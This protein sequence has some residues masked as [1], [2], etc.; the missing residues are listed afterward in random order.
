MILNIQK[1]ITLSENGIHLNWQILK[2]GRLIPKRQKE[3]APRLSLG[4][5]FLRKT[6]HLSGII[7]PV[8]YSF[9]PRNDVLAWLVAGLGVAFIVEFLRLTNSGFARLFNRYWGFLL[10]NGEQRH[11]CGATYWLVGAFLV[12]FFFPQ[13]IALFS[14]YILIVSDSLAA[15]VGRSL[16]RIRLIR[17]KTLE[18]SAAFFVSA[19]LIGS[20]IP[21]HTAGQVLVGALAGTLFELGIIPL[22]DNLTIPVGTA[23]VLAALPVL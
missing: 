22:N 15:W 8:G 18:G 2:I 20:A 9:F 5:E 7:V 16:G 10:R 19:L 11:I 12:V 17:G 14:L 4:K 23:L 1:E 13:S 21:G 3:D 6:I